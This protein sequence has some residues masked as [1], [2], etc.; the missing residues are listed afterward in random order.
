MSAMA[1]GEQVEIVRLE[2]TRIR[3]LRPQQI[4]CREIRDVAPRDDGMFSYSSGRG[5]GERVLS[6]HRDTGPS[7]V[8]RISEVGCLERPGGESGLSRLPD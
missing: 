3:I 5:E 6:G 8:R 2:K 4:D 1:C 7:S